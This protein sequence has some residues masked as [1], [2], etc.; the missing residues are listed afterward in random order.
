MPIYSGDVGGYANA[1]GLGDINPN[2]IRTYDVL[3][4]VLLQQFT[5]LVLLTV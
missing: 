1:N 3:K 2:D 4:M 5:V